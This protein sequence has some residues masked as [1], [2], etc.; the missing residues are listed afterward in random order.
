L[1]AP[2]A[3]EAFL[4]RSALQKQAML[5]SWAANVLW[6]LEQFAVF[7]VDF[8]TVS[9]EEAR[10][11]LEQIQARAKGGLSRRDGP[12]LKAAARKLVA[13]DRSILKFLFEFRFKRSDKS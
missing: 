4:E 9:I 5:C 1:L 7:D 10:H 12:S 8:V 11:R 3:P 13:I 2:C 6:L